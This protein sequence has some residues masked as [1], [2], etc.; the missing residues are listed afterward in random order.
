MNECGNPSNIDRNYQ[1]TLISLSPK[2]TD[3][4]QH[5]DSFYQIVCAPK[6]QLIMDADVGIYHL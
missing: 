3:T 6:Q 1:Y 2:G 5:F 4:L